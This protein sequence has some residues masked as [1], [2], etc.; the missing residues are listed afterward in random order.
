MTDKI[1]I[2]CGVV[3]VRSETRLSFFETTFAI[4]VIVHWTILLKKKKINKNDE[5]IEE[6]PVFRIVSTIIIIVNAVL[7]ISSNE[8]HWLVNLP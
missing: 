3:T 1:N 8:N 6:T 5:F 7:T 2:L 4:F